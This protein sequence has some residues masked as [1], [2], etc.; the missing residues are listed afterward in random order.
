[1][2]FGLLLAPLLVVCS[3]EFIVGM[4]Q[5]PVSVKG[6]IDRHLLFV[7]NRDRQIVEY[8]SR[9]MEFLVP[10]KEFLG[11]VITDVVPLNE[12]DKKAMINGFR[13]ARKHNEEQRR[14]PY[15]LQDVQFVAA[16]RYQKDKGTF[17]VK[18]RESAKKN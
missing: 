2:K 8:G 6:K 14:V 1:M 16:I 4:D 13:S 11:K 9:N 15:T 12:F 7:L 10:P 17:S 3:T 5:R 18:V